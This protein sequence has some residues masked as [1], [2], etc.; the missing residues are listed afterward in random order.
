V[1]SPLDWLVPP[2]YTIR[3]LSFYRFPGASTA[4]T[5]AE[6]MS[7][8]RLRQSF[9]QHVLEAYPLL[10]GRFERQ[11]DGTLVVVRL[12]SAGG[13]SIAAS[14]SISAQAAAAAT[15]D[16]IP[17][18]SDPGVLF[19][20]A[21]S[22]AR[23]TDLS[24][25]AAQYTSQSSL[26]SSLELLPPF[27]FASPLSNRLFVLQHTRFACGGV[28]LGVHLHHALAD[29][30]AFFQLLRD[31]GTAYRAQ[32]GAPNAETMAAP[33]STSTSTATSAASSSLSLLRLPFAPP[34]HNRSL[35]FPSGDTHAWRA[36]AAAFREDV[37]T[38][39]PI[40]LPPPS[41]SAAAAT[42]PPFCAHRV[43]RFSGDELARMKAAA[44]DPSRGCSAPWL[45][46]FEVLS[47]HLM[48]C[49]QR[50]RH[51]DRR[52]DAAA[53]SSDS[54]S[55]PLQQLH[56]DGV[57]SA[58]MA[59]SLRARPD[60]LSPQHQSQ[61]SDLARLFANTVLK[62]V[63]AMPTA[64]AMEERNGLGVAASAVHS[65]LHAQEGQENVGD[66]MSS[67]PSLS[68]TVVRRT[69]CWT[70]L[71]ADKSSIRMAERPAEKISLNSWT[72][73]G[74]Y[75]SELGPHGGGPLCFEPG[76]S[77]IRVCFPY[78]EQGVNGLIT[79][80]EAP[81]AVDDIGDAKSMQLSSSSNSGGG[82]A[83][84]VHIG[85]LQ[86]VMERMLA[87]PLLHQFA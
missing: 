65:S 83:L 35:L 81:P 4:S 49:I 31:W 74:L 40:P 2:Y 60:L 41:S 5:A 45:S 57:M 6:W 87:D 61:S 28:A 58:T 29:G 10:A 9:A 79:V 59:V 15:I 17:E 16:D 62:V 38:T 32:H 27:D 22:D 69:L 30:E 56:T 78:A 18:A 53:A 14:S 7:L 47:A 19:V 46:T 50:A 55:P 39:K 75:D 80:M 24:L 51:P 52:Y 64:A 48:R 37:Y 70:S 86:D 34:S 63:V 44:S 84:E 11:A 67:A 36:E 3:V 33:S 77:P 66:D 54:V 1:L 68:A 43:L 42:P 23:L 12:G 20:E 73:C 72:R 25:S 76:T 82:A 13:S 85:L 21:R 26:P 8:E 71:Q